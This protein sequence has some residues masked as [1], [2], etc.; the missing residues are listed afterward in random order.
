MTYFRLIALMSL[1]VLGV[2]AFTGNSNAG[3]GGGPDG[4]IDNSGQEYPETLRWKYTPRTE[5]LFRDAAEKYY[6]SQLGIGSSNSVL[7]GV[8]CQ[9]KDV[10]ISYG[11][12]GSAEI[13]HVI[14]LY[15]AYGYEEWYGM[16]GMGYDWSKYGGTLGAFTR[17]NC[18]VFF[19]TLYRETRK[20]ACVTFIHEYGHLLGR[21]HNYN[22]NSPMYV[23]Y[24]WLPD[25]RKAEKLFERN[26]KNII[27]RTVCDR[28][29]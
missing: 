21:Q 13:A 6:S 27:S 23:G 16:Q 25:Y 14:S 1:L 11:Y 2:F 12:Y 24:A 7:N 20:N 9:P 28:G 10:Q 17:G 5:A 8:P 4:S 19:N 26:R 18:R 22:I 29:W 3:G 15:L